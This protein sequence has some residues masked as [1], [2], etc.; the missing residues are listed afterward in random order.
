MQLGVQEEDELVEVRITSILPITYLCD[1]V[2]K[3]E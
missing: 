1:N 2:M 3:S